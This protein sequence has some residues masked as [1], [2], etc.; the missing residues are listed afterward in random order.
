MWLIS[1]KYRRYQ[2]KRPQPPKLH[3]GYSITYLD[4][5]DWS[6]GQIWSAAPNKSW[7]VVNQG[8]FVRVRA[9]RTSSGVYMKRIPTV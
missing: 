4:G 6:K 5:V 3:R 9:T 8:H 2:F 1:M 7:W